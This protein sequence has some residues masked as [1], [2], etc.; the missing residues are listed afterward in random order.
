MLSR[1][2]PEIDRTRRSNTW[3]NTLPNAGQSRPLQRG[4]SCKDL[5]PDLYPSRR[6]QLS[7]AKTQERPHTES[8]SLGSLVESCTSTQSITFFSDWDF[9]RP[10]LR[11]PFLLFDSPAIDAVFACKSSKRP[12][13][14]RAEMPIEAVR[15]MR[16]KLEKTS[17]AYH[18]R[19][20]NNR[21]QSIYFFDA[22]SI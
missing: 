7:W 20:S 1:S 9:G 6:H 10:H 17:D 21:L 16:R 13:V 11:N 19:A 5:F 15:K 2:P 18:S 22:I 4:S 14:R 12:E 8:R 3:P